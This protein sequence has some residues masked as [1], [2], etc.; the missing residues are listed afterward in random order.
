MKNKQKI[1]LS[2]KMEDEAGETEKDLIT[3][4]SCH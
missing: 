2:K 4:L 3:C 1:T